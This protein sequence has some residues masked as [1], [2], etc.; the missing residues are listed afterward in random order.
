MAGEIQ[1]EISIPSDDE[2]YILLQCEYCGT[3]FKVVTS[4]LHDE[5]LLN[6]YCPCCGLVSENYLTDE[7]MD[8]ANAMFENYAMDEV[9]KLFK[10][11]EK[12]SRDKIIKIKAGK[13]P[14]HIDEMPI[15]S[16]IDVLEIREFKCCKKFAKIKP[17]LTITGCYCPFCGVKSYEAK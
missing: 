14:K 4:D 15:K 6:I 13:R 7:V 3:F 11:F 16:G 12:K 10:N 9:F 1:F 8:L 2:G 5:R 17:L